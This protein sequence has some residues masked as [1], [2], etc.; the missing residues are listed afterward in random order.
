MTAS[1]TTLISRAQATLADDGTIFTT[2]MLTA[3]ARLALSDFNLRA[4]VH[5]ATLIDAVTDQHEYELTDE[6]PLAIS[7]IDILHQDDD[8][9]EFD[10]SI[11]YDDYS[12]DE[13]LFFRLRVPLDTGEI[14][15]ARYTIPHTISGLDS[16]VESTIPDSQDTTLLY[17][18]CYHAMCIRS[19]DRVE[20]INLAPAVVANY[21]NV[22]TRFLNQFERGLAKAAEKRS[23]V[24]EPDTRAW[25]DHYHTFGQ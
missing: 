16:A 12:E 7:I 10:V 4:P 22:T 14:I 17:G 1:L 8:E 6:D 11:T 9:Q 5:A 15:I 23:G 13:R 3:A 2:A 19:A 24:G 18:I 20:T 25:N 21:Q